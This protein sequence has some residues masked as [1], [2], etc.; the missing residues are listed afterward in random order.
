ME[1]KIN[2]A[3]LLKDA[4]KGTKLWS[5]AFGEVELLRVRYA[6]ANS[7]ESHRH[8]CSEDF[9]IECEFNAKD[10]SLIHKFGTDPFGRLYRY[11]ECPCILFP[12]KD[13]HT[14]ESFVAPWGHKHFE[15]FQ[16][17]LACMGGRWEAK[18]YA[19]YDDRWDR[20]KTT[21]GCCFEDDRVIS[22]E[23]NESLLGKEVES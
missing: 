23:G 16:K 7:E 6:L 2:I 17:I 1:Q 9:S 5:P 21:D 18:I 10:Y 19:R 4:P 8:N 3:E 12:S 14:W 13:C 15:P 20:H 22:Y 11:D